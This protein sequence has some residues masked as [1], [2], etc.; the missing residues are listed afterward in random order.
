MDITTI[1]SD[2][3]I[4]GIKARNEKDIIIAMTDGIAQYNGTDVQY[5]YHF[6][7]TNTRILGMKLFNNGVFVIA[8]DWNINTN[9]IFRGYLN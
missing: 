1:Q 3:F 6:S 9:Y 5:L 4:N 8:R 2:M 7:G